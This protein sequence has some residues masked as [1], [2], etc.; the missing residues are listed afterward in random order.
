M[1]EREVNSVRELSGQRE[2]HIE[3]E[4]ERENERKEAR[5]EEGEG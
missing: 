1:R 4:E 5:K 3:R 2:R